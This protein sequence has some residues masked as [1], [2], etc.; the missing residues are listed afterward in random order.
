LPKSSPK[1]LVIVAGFELK[2]E[3]PDKFY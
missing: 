1:I 2:Y 3:Q